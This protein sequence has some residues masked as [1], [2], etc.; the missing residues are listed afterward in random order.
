MSPSAETV[1]NCRAQAVEL[2]RFCRCSTVNNYCSDLCCFLQPL[3]YLGKPVFLRHSTAKYSQAPGPSLR[4]TEGAK[5][6]QDC[7]NP[8]KLK[9]LAKPEPRWFPQGTRLQ[10]PQHQAPSVS[11]S[12]QVPRVLESKVIPGSQHHFKQHLSQLAIGASC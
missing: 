12:T 2:D 3:Q 9:F 8:Q 7:S 11:A 4:V 1:E 10:A 6:A 5:A